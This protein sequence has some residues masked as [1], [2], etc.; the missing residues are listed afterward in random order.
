MKL[1]LPPLARGVE[2]VLSQQL[3]E[4]LDETLTPP[5]ARGVEGVLSQQLPEALAASGKERIRDLVKNPL[6][7][8]LLCGTWPSLD[9]DLPD[10]KAKLYQRFVTALYQ[11]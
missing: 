6:R 5:L 4:A 7:C 9:G 10:T 1:L 2:G 3:P 8:S 11:W